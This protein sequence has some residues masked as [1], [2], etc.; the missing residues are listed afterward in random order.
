MTNAVCS[1]EDVQALIE[2]HNKMHPE[3]LWTF[4]LSLGPGKR[5]YPTLWQKGSGKI[6]Q[7]QSSITLAAWMRSQM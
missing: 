7:C 1:N 3:K 5:L 4:R 2:A 6:H